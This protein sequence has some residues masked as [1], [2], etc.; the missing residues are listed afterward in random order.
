[1]RRRRGRLVER[2][3][4]SHSLPP[5]GLSQDQGAPALR[6]PR[7]V[8][9]AQLEGQRC[10][11][12]ALRGCEGQA[13]ARARLALGPRV[14]PQ[15]SCWPLQETPTAAGPGYLHGVGKGLMGAGDGQGGEPSAS[16]VPEPLLT[17]LR[18]SGTLGA[19]QTDET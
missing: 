11:G 19:G 2:K 5:Q 18:I 13:G 3:Q 14:N 7:P 12:A 16:G 6:P 15:R 9:K 4:A 17:E 10:W 1:M 8:E